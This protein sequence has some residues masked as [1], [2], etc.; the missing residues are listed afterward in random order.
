M[1]KLLGIV[2]LSFLC[3]NLVFA[4]EKY[5]PLSKIN[6]KL[7]GSIEDLYQSIPNINKAECEI[8]FYYNG[9]YMRETLNS[10][11]SESDFFLVANFKN[12]EANIYCEK[13]FYDIKDIQGKSISHEYTLALDVCGG[14]IYSWHVTFGLAHDELT[15]LQKPG[16]GENPNILKEWINAFQYYSDKEPEIKKKRSESKDYKDIDGKFHNSFSNSRSWYDLIEENGKRF[17]VFLTS[18]INGNDA[19]GPTSHF[20]SYAVHD[21]SLNRTGYKCRG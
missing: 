14:R 5:K 3:S 6:L 4:Y 10:T 8:R 13:L 15:L 7:W 17:Q 20:V 1:R 18:F 9:S 21:M 16:F 11:I 19:H 2:V 12:K